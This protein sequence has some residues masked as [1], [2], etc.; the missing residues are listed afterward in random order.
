MWLIVRLKKSKTPPE[1]LENTRKQEKTQ[2]TNSP[3]TTPPQQVLQNRKSRPIHDQMPPATERKA[4]MSRERV[5]E[6]AAP[7]KDPHKP[8]KQELTSRRGCR[9]S[10]SAKA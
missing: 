5:W 2:K 6:P 9:W 4:A 7:D 8:Q 3:I 10:P 1:A